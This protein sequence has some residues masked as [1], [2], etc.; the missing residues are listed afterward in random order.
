MQLMQNLK[1]YGPYKITRER[2]P[3]L[4]SVQ[5]WFYFSF[6]DGEP[7]LECRVRFLSFLGIGQNV[8]QAAFIMHTAQVSHK[9][10]APSLP[11]VIL[12]YFKNAA[13]FH[14]TPHCES[15]KGHGLQGE[16]ALLTH[17]FR[18]ADPQPVIQQNIRKIMEYP[19]SSWD[20]A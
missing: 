12:P 16:A 6:M 18:D 19:P 5:W 10:L 11:F 9:H 17:N 7:P 4:M 14:W 15:G 8:Q 20:Q 2:G 3:W 1:K 13:P